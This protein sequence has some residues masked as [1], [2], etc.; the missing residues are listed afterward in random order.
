MKKIF[1]VAFIAM[2]VSGIV[3][4]AVVQ[5]QDKITKPYRFTLNPG[6]R[7]VVINSGATATITVKPTTARIFDYKVPAGKSFSGVLIEK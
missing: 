4:A 2:A 7:I 5:I 6:D 3:Y 1:F